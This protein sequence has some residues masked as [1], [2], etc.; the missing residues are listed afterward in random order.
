MIRKRGFAIALSC[1]VIGSAAGFGSL[2]RVFG[3]A[4]AQAQPATPSGAQ[5]APSAQAAAAPSAPADG[6]PRDSVV[7]RVNDKTITL[8]DLERRIRLMPPF[9]LKRYGGT[10]D[11]IKKRFL[12]EVLVRELV[13]TQGALDQGLEK[14]P[15]IDDKLKGILRSALFEELKKGAALR[16]VTDEE[17]KKFYDDNADK[18]ISPRRISI[19]RILVGSEPE[20]REIIEEMKKGDDVK[21]WNQLARDKSLDKASSMRSGNLGFVNPDGTTAQPELK[22]DVAI[23]DAADKAKDGEVVASPVKE[24]DKWAVV[25]RRQAMRAVTRQ[26]DGESPTIR[27]A[28]VDEKM[29]KSVD[30][31]MT[32]LRAN[33]VSEMHPELCDMVTVS[34]TGDI[35]KAKRPGILPRSR[36]NGQ[37]AP[38]EGPAGLR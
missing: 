28:L 9:M 20:A 7:A 22:L 12:D 36:Q 4:A 15:E 30:E 32:S 13:L 17:V 19:W 18:Y 29:R 23:F 33:N 25:W 8:G 38:A 35:E 3:P 16:A 10:S 34:E 31:L 26:L 27:S 1:A 11:E 2:A 5:A 24:G 37:P 14:R 6:V 21:K